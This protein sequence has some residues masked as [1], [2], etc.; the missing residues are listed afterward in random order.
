MNK[1]LYVGGAAVS[2]KCEVAKWGSEMRENH[3]LTTSL[4]T[5]IHDERQMAK[6]KWRVKLEEMG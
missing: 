1:S 2:W 4:S 3:D 6:I 5:F